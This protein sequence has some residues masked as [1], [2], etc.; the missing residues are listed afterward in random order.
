MRNIE[1]KGDNMPLIIQPVNGE[2]EIQT[3]LVE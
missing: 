1:V 3:Q 2:A